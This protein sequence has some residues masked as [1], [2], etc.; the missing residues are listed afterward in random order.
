MTAH[1]TERELREIQAVAGGASLEVIMRRLLQLDRASREEYE[2]LR[3]QSREA[4]EEWR[5][6]RSRR[7]KGGPP[8]HRLQLR[9]RGRP[10][11]RSVF[12]GYAEGV[13][14]LSEVVD[15]VGVRTKHLDNL[16]REAFG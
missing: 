13:V 8:P 9:D 14:T 10:F 6:A 16:Q 2:Q 3:H 12:D 7:S 11:V 4:Y 1:W 5:K 15:L